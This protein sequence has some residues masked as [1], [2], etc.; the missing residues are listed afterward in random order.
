MTAFSRRGQTFLDVLIV[1]VILFV[2]AIAF[3]LISVV[4]KEIHDEM[5]GSEG[6]EADTDAGKAL[7]AFDEH[8]STSLD[9]TMLV[10]FVLFWVFVIVSSLF[11]D[12]NPVFLIVSVILL[13]IVLVIMGVMSNTYEEFIQD[14]DLYT[15]ANGFPKTNY[16]M[17]HLVMFCTF[18]ALSGILAIYGKNSFGGG[19]V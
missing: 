5:Y 16:I 19:G 1:A 10:V 12:A 13:V 11:V 9:N 15:F 8:F 3:I 6:F 2:S 18:I 17:E 14:G 7:Q 4:Q